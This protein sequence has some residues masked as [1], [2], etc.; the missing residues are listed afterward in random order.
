MAR[1]A[2]FLYEMTLTGVWSPV[3]YYDDPPRKSVNGNGR[4]QSVVISLSTDDP[5]LFSSDESPNFAALSTA[6]PIQL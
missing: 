3:V 5:V 1:R 2:F 4:K 6:Y